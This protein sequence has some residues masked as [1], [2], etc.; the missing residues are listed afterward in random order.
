MA[1]CDCTHCLM[2]VFELDT[3]VALIALDIRYLFLVVMRI[4]FYGVEAKVGE[5]RA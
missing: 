3:L 1:F 5:E 4:G 2:T